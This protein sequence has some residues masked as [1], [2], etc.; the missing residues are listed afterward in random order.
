M[1]EEK[2]VRLPQVS[3]TGPCNGDA[4]FR[5]FILIFYAIMPNILLG[6]ACEDGTG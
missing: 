5:R 1:G 6:I 2:Q 4:L 3:M